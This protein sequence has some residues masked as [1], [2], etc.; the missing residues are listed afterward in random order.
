MYV[1][2]W[3][4]KSDDSRHFETTENLTKFIAGAK[5]LTCLNSRWGVDGYLCKI[6]LQRPLLAVYKLTILKI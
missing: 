6:L 1:Y 3:C 4:Q 5:L 2:E